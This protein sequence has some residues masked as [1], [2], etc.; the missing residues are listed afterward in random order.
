MFYFFTKDHPRKLL[1]LTKREVSSF[2][3]R[4]HPIPLTLPE[5][6]SLVNCKLVPMLCYRQIAHPLPPQQLQALRQHLWTALAGQGGVST[7][8]SPKD[9]DQPKLRLSLN[10]CDLTFAI[11]KFTV[12]S[13]I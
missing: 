4:L 1:A 11:H 6:V 5:L 3:Q 13:G 10:I 8:L 2:F 9:H 7:K 12:A